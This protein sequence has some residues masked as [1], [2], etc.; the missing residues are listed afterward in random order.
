MPVSGCRIDLLPDPSPANSRRLQVIVV[1]TA[2]TGTTS[3]A[4]ALK[5]LGYNTA[6]GLGHNYFIE[7]L[8]PYWTEA[9]NAKYNNVGRL[10]SAEDFDKFVGKYEAVTGWHCALMAEELVAAFPNAKVILT[11]RDPDEWVESY[12]AAVAAT[13]KFWNARRWVFLWTCWYVLASELI[14]S[15]ERQASPLLRC[16]FDHRALTH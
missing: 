8:Y 3:L 5:K 9:V 4:A 2:R 1:G 14:L 15:G 16:N 6:N 7:N 12:N 10:Y 11:D 13:H